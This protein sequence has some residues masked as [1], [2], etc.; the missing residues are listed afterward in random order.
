MAAGNDQ[1]TLDYGAFLADLEA[2]KTALEHAIASLRALMAGGALSG[3]SGATVPLSDLLT[4]GIHGGDVPVGAFLG[5]SIPEATKLC[6]Q[7]TKKK[8]TTRE[9]TDALL[10]G[11]I[12]TTAKTSFPSIVH[13]VLMRAA[14]SGSSIVKLDRSHWG[15]AEWYPASL[16][17][18]IPAGRVKSKKRQ[19]VNHK[20]KAARPESPT[21]KQT[22]E[23]GTIPEKI[24]ETLREPG[25]ALSAQEI[26]A[27]VGTRSNVAAMLLG[28]LIRMKWAE[29]MANGKYRAIK[30][31]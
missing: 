7:I 8:L 15:L 26:A 10:K 14:R 28:K 11:G 1:K 12:E 22:E 13:S 2:K 6:L 3:Q 17:T 23:S 4:A 5:K 18:S 29:K 31:A 24:W 16:R 19:K 27:K 30:I 20:P 25:V 9:I 21:S